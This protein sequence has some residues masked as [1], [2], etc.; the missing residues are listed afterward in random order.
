MSLKE[1]TSDDHWLK[2]VSNDETVKKFLR[3]YHELE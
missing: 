1:K 2:H 3:V